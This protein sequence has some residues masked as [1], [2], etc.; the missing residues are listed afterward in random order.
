MLDDFALSDASLAGGTP[1][2]EVSG[3]LDL[4]AAPQLS[5]RLLDA[6]DD[7]GGPVVVD[8]TEATFIDSTI[9]GVLLTLARRLGH[10]GKRLVVVADHPHIRRVIDLTGVAKVLTVVDTREQ[11]G[12]V[13]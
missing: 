1:V 4:L 10:H 2:V 9:L 13:L 11:A 3:E 8:L 6:S 12:A 7:C 5:R